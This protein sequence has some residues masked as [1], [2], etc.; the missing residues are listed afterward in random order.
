MQKGPIADGDRAF[1]FGRREAR[2]NQAKRGRRP[3]PLRIPPKGEKQ[4]HAQ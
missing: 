3:S 2:N 4:P 1:C